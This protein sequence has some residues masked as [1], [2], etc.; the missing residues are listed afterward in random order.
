FESAAGVDI[1][2]A[3]IEIARRLV[4]EAELHVAPLR[5]LPFP[6]ASFDLVV[7]NDVLQHVAEAEVA[8]SLRELRRVLAPGGALL[9]RTNGARTLRR[10]RDDWRAYDRSTLRRELLG[11]GFADVRVTYA[12]AVVSLTAGLGGPAPPP[13]SEN[14]PGE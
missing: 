4:P 13:P 2:S 9:L 3:A 6:G 10:E 14:S 7:T 8:A 5:E 11:A 1:G 12:N